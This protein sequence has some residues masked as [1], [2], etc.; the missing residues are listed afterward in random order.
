MAVRGFNEFGGYDNDFSVRILDRHLCKVC[1]KVL[2]EPQLLV[3]CGE[4]DCEKCLSHSFEIAH[5]RC[6]PH[7]GAEG[8]K[9][10]YVLDK[11]LKTE[12][13]GLKV[14]LIRETLL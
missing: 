3:C 14:C 1:N 6:C 2:N 13:L 8:A 10:Q 11:G 5:K 7:C 9:L 4:H 12:I